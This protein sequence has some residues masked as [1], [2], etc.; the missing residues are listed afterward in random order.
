MSNPAVHADA[1]GLIVRCSSCGKSTRLTYA[2]LG[3]HFRCA[4]CQTDVTPPAE[5]V[6][7]PSTEVFDALIAASVLPVLVDFWA[8]WCGPCRTLAPELEQAARIGANRWLVFKV[9]TEELPDLAQRFQIASIPT[10]ALFLRGREAAR[11]SGALPAREIVRF[12]ESNLPRAASR[13]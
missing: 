5:P 7:A 6:A 3:S 10:L 2:R 13:P 11:Q 12:I 8:P 1:R 9:N 4:A